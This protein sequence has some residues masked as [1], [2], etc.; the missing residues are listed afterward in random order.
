M[1]LISESNST[2]FTSDSGSASVFRKFKVKLKVEPSLILLF[3]LMVPS[4][5]STSCFTMASPNPVPPYN[6]EVPLDACW[7][8]SKM[9]SIFLFG[10]PIPVSVTAN[11][12]VTFSS[13]S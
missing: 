7:K 4:C 5:A 3:T 8:F 11:S 12:M 9:V 1:F 10:I 2:I 13:S 6:L